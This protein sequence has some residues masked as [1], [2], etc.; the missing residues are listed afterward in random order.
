[1][2]EIDFLPVESKTGPGSKS[3]DAI[4]LRFASPTEAK[5]TVVVIDG[6]Y[7]PIGQA[8]AHHIKT[9]YGTS[10]IDLVVSTHPDADHLNGL[11]ELLEQMEVSELMLHLPWQHHNEVSK[12]SNIEKIREL[13]G[14][15]FNKGVPVTEPFA[16]LSR[17][18]DRLR[19]LGP[20]TAFYEELL[21]QDIGGTNDQASEQAVSL[22]AVPS[23]VAASAQEVQTLDNL[24][25]VSAR[26]NSSVIT[27][28]TDAGEDHLF[29]GDAGIT[30]LKAAADELE[31]VRHHLPVV[32]FFQVP[33]HG[34]RRNLG[35]EILDRWF[36]TGGSEITAF[37]S[38]G[39][40]DEK[41]PGKAVMTE[42]R[43]RGFMIYTTEGGHL[44][45]HHDG[46]PRPTYTAAI[47]R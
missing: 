13:Y 21:A 25:T 46:H 2:I 33:H 3:G 43:Q 29:T 1:M 32:E 5:P 12:Y 7:G 27:V 28:I 22:N 20:T 9:F 6:G 11:I 24:D 26:N 38:S 15:A 36:P 18:D 16:G 44:F 4:C 30:A 41:H 31:R 39:L 35:P 8:L 47:P 23:S 19:I 45:H 10:T 37:V 14:L 40:A 34:S 17:F 42:L